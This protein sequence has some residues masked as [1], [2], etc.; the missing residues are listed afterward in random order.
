MRQFIFQSVVSNTLQ[1]LQSQ[2]LKSF[3]SSFFQLMNQGQSE[4]KVMKILSFRLKGGGA[5]ET[6]VTKMILCV[7][8]LP[9][10]YDIIYPFLACIHM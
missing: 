10:S 7:T 5:V 1:H 6:N 3:Q 8:I 2:I 9:F 4:I